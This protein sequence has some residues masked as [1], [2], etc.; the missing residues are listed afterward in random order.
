MRQLDR[1]G[2]AGPLTGP[3]VRGDVATLRAHLAR[4]ADGTAEER[5]IHR[6]LSLRLARLALDFGESD[7][8]ATLAAFGGSKRKRG[9]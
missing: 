9:V 1:S 2:L 8:A 3:A 5:E 6:L 4:L 7:A